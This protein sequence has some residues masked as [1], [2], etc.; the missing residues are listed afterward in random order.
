MAVILKDIYPNIDWI[1]TAGQSNLRSKN[2]HLLQ[3]K[4]V[5]LF[6]DARGRSNNE[7]NTTF[8]S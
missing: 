5:V 6:P 3:D 8:L 2:L 4:K 1:A 7:K